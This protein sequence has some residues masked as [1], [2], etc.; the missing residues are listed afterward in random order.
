[1]IRRLCEKAAGPLLRG[2]YTT[3]VFAGL[4]TV[5]LAAL[6]I[7][8]PSAQG[9][10]PA[11]SS[12]PSA[13]PSSPSPDVADIL[14]RAQALKDLHRTNEALQ[15]VEDAMQ[16]PDAPEVL[17]SPDLHWVQAWLLISLGESTGRHTYIVDAAAEFRSVVLLAG[18]HTDLGRE[19]QH[20]LD[21]ISKRATSRPADPALRHR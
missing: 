21:R 15:V 2:E 16:L 6:L 3:L 9:R 20:A 8:T 4:L 14:A 18:A 19:A 10:L 1:M 11:A 12:P 5:G 13:T 17:T 7:L